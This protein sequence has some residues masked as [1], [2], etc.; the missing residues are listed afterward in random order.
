MKGKVYLVGAG[1]GDPELLTVKALRLLRSA[2]AVLHDDLVVPEI[3]ALISPTAQIHNVGKRCGKKKILQ[4]E[5]NFLMIALADSGLRVVRLKSGDPL[6]FGRAGEEI[7]SLRRA[8]IAFEIVPGVTSSFGAAAV[9]Q[10]PL[11][12]RHASSALVLL[13]AHQAAGSE[14]TNWSRL[15][16][17]GATLVIY[18]PGKNYSEIGMKL[19]ASGVAPETPCA[20][21]SRAT[22]RHQRTHRTTVSQ[23]RTSPELPAPTLLVVG[24]VV[25]FADAASL[26]SEFFV[27]THVETAASVMPRSLFADSSYHI[28]VADVERLEF[29]E[30]RSHSRDRPDSGT[31]EGRNRTPAECRRNLE[32]AARAGLGLRDFRKPSRHL[33]GFRRRRHGI[34]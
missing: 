33:I 24:E 4:E 15:A 20:V 1:P 21:I 13:T 12:H 10:I 27:S 17:S 34:D 9:A 16:G 32:S 8:N 29:E 18:M 23:L 28:A 5:I 6:I 31:S 26:T 22:T 7:E 3:L 11:T 25:R 14:A 2:E 30:K 19:R